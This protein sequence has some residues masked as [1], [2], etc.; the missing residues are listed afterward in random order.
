MTLPTGSR[1]GCVSWC[2]G[3]GASGSHVSRILSLAYSPGGYLFWS[4]SGIVSKP[5]ASTFGWQNWVAEPCLV[6]LICIMSRVMGH[7]KIPLQMS[8]IKGRIWIPGKRM[9][10]SVSR[11]PSVSLNFGF[12]YFY[13]KTNGGSYMV[14]RGRAVRQSFALKFKKAAVVQP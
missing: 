8:W 14:V 11:G 3:R 1:R 10:S 13:E 2:H 7:V 4:A 6:C 9:L 12:F 5:T